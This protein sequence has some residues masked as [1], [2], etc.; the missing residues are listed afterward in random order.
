MLHCLLLVHNRES[1][2]HACK[3]PDRQTHT[4]RTGVVA[5]CVSLHTLIG[6]AARAAPCRLPR[7]VLCLVNPCELSCHGVCA[8]CVASRVVVGRVTRRVRRPC[9]LSLNIAHGTRI[10]IEPL[11]GNDAG[12]SGRVGQRVAMSVARH[13]VTTPVGLVWRFTSP[14]A[15]LHRSTRHDGSRT[16]RDGLM[17]SHEVFRVRSSIDRGRLAL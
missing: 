10:G 17:R 16:W 2:R 3:V 5:R 8:P 15:E 12:E 7:A 9:A 11:C 14:A 1:S 4:D 6:V 13:R